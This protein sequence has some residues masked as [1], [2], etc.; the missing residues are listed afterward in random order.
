MHRLDYEIRQRGGRLSPGT[1]TVHDQI[2]TGGAVWN[3]LHG[4]VRGFSENG[5]PGVYRITMRNGG[6]LVGLYR[7]PEALR[8]DGE[9]LG[10]GAEKVEVFI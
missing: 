1:V 6:H 4:L 8:A 2:L 5:S 7:S 3:A 10:P 9:S